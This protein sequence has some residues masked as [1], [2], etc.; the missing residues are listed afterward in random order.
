[1]SELVTL[2]RPYAE[3]AFKR[4]KET[5]AIAKWSDTL[6]FL[7]VVMQDKQIATI[8]DNPK[9]A[10]EKIQSLLLDICQGQLDG[11]TENF[12]KLLVQNKRLCLA[13]NVAELFEQF[14]AEHEGYIDVDVLTAFAFSAEE[15]KKFT[16]TL[17][18][19]LK[20]KVRANV[21]LDKSLIGGVIV[22]AGDRVI[23]GSV[24]GQLQ[25]MHKALQ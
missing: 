6:T 24:K 25:H 5:D 20:K 14:R 10:S 16:A 18:N 3:A 21:V 19:L 4:A 1:M 8:V 9:V 23:D 12:V 11:E 13:P 15:Q 7:S 2:A 22:R 17:E